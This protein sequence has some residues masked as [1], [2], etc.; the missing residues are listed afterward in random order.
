MLSPRAWP[1]EKGRGMRYAVGSLIVLALGLLP[2]HVA[3]A[4]EV[5]LA[6]D[7]VAGSSLT[8]IYQSRGPDC[9]N[10]AQYTPVVDVP[11]PTSTVTLPQLDAGGT[12]CWVARA[13]DAAGAEGLV[14]YSIGY[15]VP[16]AALT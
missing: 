16:G 5:T 2:G 14:S 3:A 4:A 12:Y 13:V 8:R 7:V 15:A 1:G 10:G 9:F 11:A 6:W